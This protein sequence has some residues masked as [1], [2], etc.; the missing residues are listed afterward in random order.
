MVVDAIPPPSVLSG[1]LRPRGNELATNGPSA[2]SATARPLRHRID[3]EIVGT[4]TASPTRAGAAGPTPSH[5]RQTRSPPT[6][7]Y[8]TRGIAS[9]VADLRRHLTG[10]AGK[11]AA[12]TWSRAPAPTTPSP[13][14]PKPAGM[15]LPPLIADDDRAADADRAGRPRRERPLPA[16]DHCRRRVP[17]H[18]ERGGTPGKVGATPVIIRPQVVGVGSAECRCRTPW[19]SRPGP[20]ARRRSR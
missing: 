3:G 10:Q 9:P 4:L 14:S 19:C 17:G 18:R 16:G 6:G 7:G 13:P 15:S 8:A 2:R 5:H 20:L 11:S 12:P 1:M